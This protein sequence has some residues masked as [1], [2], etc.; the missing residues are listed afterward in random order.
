[1]RPFAELLCSHVMMNDDYPRRLHSRRRGL[2]VQ[3]RRFVCLF[4]RDL[5]EKRLELSA[6][7]SVDT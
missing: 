6:P 5:K 3:S 2:G 4:V 7:K 1:M